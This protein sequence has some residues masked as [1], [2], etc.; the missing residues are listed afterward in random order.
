M[1]I[2]FQTDKR[3]D[4]TYAY[5]ATY[6]WDRDK[7]QSCSVRKLIGRVDG[8]GN[9]VPTDGRCRK[10]KPTAEKLAKSA[11]VPTS[12]TRH[13]YCGATYLLDEISE[14]TGLAKDLCACF[15]DTYKELLSIAYYL[16]LED[17]NPLY[18]FEKW[19]QIHRHPYGSDISSPRSSEFFSSITDQ[20]IQ[21]FFRLQGKRRIAEEYWAYDSTSISSYSETLRQIQYGKNKENDRLPQLNL[22]LVFGE[23]SGLPFYYRKL[24]GNIPDSKTVN[25]LLGELDILGFKKTKI[26]MDRGF[27]SEKNINEMYQEHV[28][29]LLGAKTSL[30]FVKK[31]LD[32]VYDD[33]RLYPNYDENTNTY[34]YTIRTRWDY[35]QNRP[36]KGDTIEDQRRI[37]VHLY[38]NIDKGAEDEAAFD[39]K[40][41]MWYKELINNDRKEANAK[42]YAKY[43]SVK[44]TPKRGIQVVANEEALKKARRYFGYFALI[45]NEKMDAFTALHLYRTKDVVEKAFGNIK[46]RLNMRRLLLS[47]ERGLAGKLFAQFI[48][49]IF[50]SYIHQR[51]KVQNLYKKY[52]MHQ[53]LDKLD[54]IECFEEPGR[55]SRVGEI[56]TEQMDI[57]KK[58]GVE[59]PTSL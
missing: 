17:D 29:F 18:R 20:Q 10:D 2:I 44:N 30:S 24:A 54:V 45:T 25:H 31:N 35:R 27:Y 1:A 21:Q 11:P 58:M 49:L 4:I 15:P 34:G 12:V 14:A 50:I 38:Y 52:T 59:P 55:K 28:K 51:M 43:F 32:A 16:A 23:K 22:L 42:H 3:S 53:I 47:S 57:Y 39:K 40:V 9:V 41:A 13:Q 36:Y 19:G 48:A 5:V 33:I 46:E 8:S 56:L 26:V 37:Y 6:T 7:K